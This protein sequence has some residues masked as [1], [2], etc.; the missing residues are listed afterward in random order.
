MIPVLNGIGVDA[1]CVGV[2]DPASQSRQSCTPDA[3]CFVAQDTNVN[4]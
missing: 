1:A 3:L 2:S 4:H